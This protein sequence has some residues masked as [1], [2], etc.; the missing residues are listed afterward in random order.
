MEVLPAFDETKDGVTRLGLRAKAPPVQQLAFKRREEALSLR[1]ALMTLH[2]RLVLRNS[3]AA[4]SLMEGLDETL[5]LRRLGA[6]S[7]N[8]DSASRPPISLS[9]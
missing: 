6:Y 4:K 8:W 5:T 2:A 9:R 3:S 1:A 7:T